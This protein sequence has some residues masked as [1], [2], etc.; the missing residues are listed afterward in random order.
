MR[1]S[2]TIFVGCGWSVAIMRLGGKKKLCESPACVLVLQGFPKLYKHRLCTV[3]LGRKI[4]RHT[5][6][7][8]AHIRP[9]CF[10]LSSSPDAKEGKCSWWLF[11]ILQWLQ[12]DVGLELCVHCASFKHYS[13]QLK[14][15]L[16]IPPVD[17]LLHM[18][19]AFCRLF[20]CVLECVV[21][22]VWGL[23]Q[24]CGGGLENKKDVAY[25]WPSIWWLSSVAS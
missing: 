19:K 5:A 10:S 13:W 14:R 1:T 16:A 11:L 12:T 25:S 23:C 22:C 18:F 9:G 21:C 24:L 4:C 3:F 17:S 6:L 8:G 2:W 20:V 7:N 15:S